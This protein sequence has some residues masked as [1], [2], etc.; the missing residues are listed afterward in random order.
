[1]YY[2]IKFRDNNETKYKYTETYMEM[3]NYVK[4]LNDMK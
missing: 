2:I 1:M 4:K 3:L